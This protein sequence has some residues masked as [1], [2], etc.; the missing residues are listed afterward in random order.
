MMDTIESWYRDANHCIVIDCDT[1]CEW[2]CMASYSWLWAIDANMYAIQVTKLQAFNTLNT[3]IDCYYLIALA[4]S[5]AF[6]GILNLIT[7]SNSKMS[8]NFRTNPMN[9]FYKTPTCTCELYTWIIIHEG[10]EYRNPSIN[11]CTCIVH[12]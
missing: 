11:T 12:L 10:L 1:T 9:F 8:K 4:H 7:K 6:Y 5:H 3:F 2:N